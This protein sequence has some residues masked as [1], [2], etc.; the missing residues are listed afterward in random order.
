MSAASR[1]YRCES[2]LDRSSSLPP[3]V[4]SNECTPRVVGLATGTERKLGLC[5]GAVSR[6]LGSPWGGDQ[7]SAPVTGREAL[8]IARMPAR[9]GG[10]RL[11]QASTTAERSGSAESVWSTVWS[12]GSG[13]PVSP[14]ESAAR[15]PIANPPSSV[16]LR[17]EPLRHHPCE[18]PE[19]P[20]FAGVF[21][22][23][24]PAAPKSRQPSNLPQSANPS[25]F[26]PTLRQPSSSRSAR[27]LRRPAARLDARK[28]SPPSTGTS[29][30]AKAAMM[31]RGH[32]VSKSSPVTLVMMSI[33]LGGTPI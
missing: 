3:P 11:S 9:T 21:A 20:G 8:T 6:P 1:A 18:L 2:A 15:G 26:G 14:E 31:R 5:G 10:G 27:S 30:P 29:I 19:L 16:R 13:A 25:P 24:G 4:W 33:R 22:F 12:T 28:S 7:S 23:L 17:P 32:A